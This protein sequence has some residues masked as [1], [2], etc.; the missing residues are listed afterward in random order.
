MG[1]AK[2]LRNMSSVTKRM[3]SS[4]ITPAFW[5]NKN[6]MVRWLLGLGTVLVLTFLL[7]PTIELPSTPLRVGDIAPRDFKAPENFLVED[8][9]STVKRRLE[10]MRNVQSVYDFDTTLA[11]DIREGLKVAFSAAKRGRGGFREFEDALGVSL[12]VETRTLLRKQ[13]FNPRIGELSAVLV[14]RIM[15]QGVTTAGEITEADRQK[16]IVLQEVSANTESVMADPTALLEMSRL[17]NAIERGLRGVVP[18]GERYLGPAVADVAAAV[19]EANVSLNRRETE[20][21]KAAAYQAVKP[22]YMQV[23]KGEMIVREGEKISAEQ[24]SKLNALNSLR[25]KGQ[26][27]Y[28]VIGLNILIILLIYIIWRYIEK[29]KPKLAAHFSTLVLLSVILVGNLALVKMSLLMAGA[30]ARSVSYIETSSYFYAFPY[31]AGAMVIVILFSADVGVVYSLISALLIGIMMREGWSYPLVA[32]IGGLAA[33]SRVGEYKKR[34]AIT[35]TGL[36][37][38]LANIVTIVALNLISGELWSVKGFFEIVMGF[39]GG[40]LAAMVV[41]GAL[42]IVESVFGVTSDIKLLE[43]ADLNHPLLRRLVVQAPGTYHHSILVG[44]LAEEAASAIGANA[45]L[46]RVGSYFHDIGKAN[47]PEYFVENQAGVK[48]KDDERSPSMSSLVLISHV[49]EGIEMARHSKL[50]QKIIDMIPQHHGTSLISYFY[51]KAKAQ[52]D[53]EHGLVKEEDYRYPGPKPQSKEA[54]IVLLADPVEAA[55]RA[56]VDP[57]PARIQGL[58]Q[59]IVNSRFIDGQLDECDLTLRDLHLITK[60]FLRILTGIFHQR[61]SYPETE[62]RTSGEEERY[63]GNGTA[64]RKPAKESED[65][66]AEDKD[67]AGEII[68]RLGMSG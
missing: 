42:P 55:S 40:V 66:S 34:S 15:G 29:F 28:G 4:A 14:Q 64:G 59:R 6:Q 50:P 13:G 47:R 8:G 24:V 60:S 23:Q 44:N 26:G 22:V 16:G 31:T 57:T 68:R 63:N 3:L 56:L 41:S 62:E 21:R 17:R 52:E 54:A 37:V 45:L 12:P 27:I 10:A 9:T 36:L 5:M 49:K 19:I 58:V 11:P 39:L 67:Q 48:N 51:N 32:L 7:A 53:P 25:R 2:N 46:A 33:T 43:L 1:A 61:L 18:A 20:Q 65:R 38:G 35:E 30:L